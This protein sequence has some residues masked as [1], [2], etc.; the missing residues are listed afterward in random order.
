M[1][2]APTR[3]ASHPPRPAQQTHI[4]HPRPVASRGGCCIPDIRVTAR[5]WRHDSRSPQL[6]KWIR[7]YQASQ[8]PDS[9]AANAAIPAGSKRSAAAVQSGSRKGH[10]HKTK[11]GGSS[12][13]KVARVASNHTSTRTNVP[14]RAAAQRVSSFTEVMME[15]EDDEDEDEDDE[16]LA[17]EEGEE[18]EI[19]EVEAEAEAPAEAEEPDEAT[20]AIDPL[21]M[22]QRLHEAS[23]P[24]HH[25]LLSVDVNLA[26]DEYGRVAK[27]RRFYE[28][29]SSE[30]MPL[31]LEDD[32]STRLSVTSVTSMTESMDSSLRGG[33]AF[34]EGG[35]FSYGIRAPMAPSSPDNQ[36]VMS[37][38]RASNNLPVGYYKQHASPTVHLE[39]SP[40]YHAQADPAAC[41]LPNTSC[42]LVSLQGSLLRTAAPLHPTAATIEDRQQGS[43]GFMY[44]FGSGRAPPSP[45]APTPAPAAAPRMHQDNFAAALGVCP[46]CPALLS[47]G[48]YQSR[49][50]N[51]SVAPAINGI[52]G[53]PPSVHDAVTLA[54]PIA[55]PIM[56][57]QYVSADAT[58]HG[59]RAAALSR[60][61]LAYIAQDGQVVSAHHPATLAGCVVPAVHAGEM[62]SSGG[63]EALQALDLDAFQWVDEWLNEVQEVGE[64]G[65]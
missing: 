58:V 18:S 47:H 5:H 40:P 59:Q 27:V 53:P 31:L 6:R 13:R 52:N 8:P 39:A 37:A 16:S 32:D 15:L 60:A 36:L 50:R 22:H 25:T 56:P 14:K 41:Y 20:V 11:G 7:N 12:A 42:G 45:P 54:T 3:C 63:G 44:T 64:V 10:P 34:S 23:H 29:T 24:G 65:A 61:H 28:P 38:K 19:E 57:A 51:L 43:G 1:P 21:A 55:T 17:G 62:A 26:A 49:M 46:P 4:P 35:S 30:V 33:R 48:S 9:P 2:D